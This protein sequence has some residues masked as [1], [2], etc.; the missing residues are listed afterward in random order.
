[1][2]QKSECCG[3]ENQLVQEFKHV[4]SCWCCFLM[5]GILLV[6][7]GTTAIVVPPLTIAYTLA[8]VIVLGV[9]LMV[10]GIVTIVSSFWI[11]KWS[12]MLLH[13]L[14]GILYVV[15]GFIITERPGE[16]TMLMTLFI[17]VTFIVLGAF[18]I[19]SA[20][21]IRFPQWGWI[22]FNGII[23]FLLGVVIY[24]HLRESALWV[25]GILVGVELI[26]NGWSWIMLALAVRKI[27]K[28]L[29]AA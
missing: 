5:L 21:A 19:V 23:T 16:A 2:N 25:I 28:E 11:G 7:C 14:A 29:P 20:L 18:R 8:T 26:F 27:P 1:M 15:I 17:A 24:R 10:A 6:L 4:R 22:L 12:G 13:L 3:V 9:L